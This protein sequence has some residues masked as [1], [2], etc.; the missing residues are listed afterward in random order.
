MG[1]FYN[2][3]LIEEIRVGN[4]IVSVVSEYVKLE[5]KGKNYFGLCP[6]HR[7]KTPSFSI[8]P[9]KQIFYCFGCGKGGN[10]IHFT[11]AAENIE[12]TEAIKFLAERSGVTLPEGDGSGELEKARLRKELFEVNKTAARY[13][14]ENLNSEAGHAAKKY[15]IERGLKENTLRRFG[16]GFSAESSDSLC[17]YMEAHGS[18][19]DMLAK[20]GLAIAGKNHMFYDRFK[21]RVMFP[22]FDLRGNITGFGGRIIEANTS[23]PKYVNSPE[24]PVYSKSR[25][26]YALN[27][28]KNSGIGTLLV[29][30]GYMDV[31]SLHQ[32]G[33]INSVASLGTSLTEGQARL[34]KKYS[35]EIVISF[36]S[37]AAGQSAAMRSL[38][39]LDEMGC[40][41]RVLRIPEGKDPDD[42]IKKK[43]PA[44][45]RK[46]IETAQPVVEYKTAILKQEIDTGSTEGKIKF[47]SRLAEIL[48]KLDSRV[49]MEMYARKIARDYG[50]SEES[51]YGEITRKTKPGTSTR[52]IKSRESASVIKI[53]DNEANKRLKQYEIKLLSVLCTDN[54]AYNDIKG[55]ITPMDF[56]NGSNRKIAEI[57]F[58]RLDNNIE[59]APAELFNILDPDIA[60]DYAGIIEKDCIYD[61]YRKAAAD[62]AVKIKS[63]HMERR[64]VELMETLNGKEKL[65]PEDLKRL[66]GELDGILHQKR[67]K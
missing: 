43:G 6:F 53:T 38:D 12:F 31:I 62:I 52:T 2:D 66:L 42:Y 40:R 15:L 14:Y 55:K 24:T 8:E 49:E 47:I 44:A 16:L 27:L 48:S 30:E 36:D 45:F 17:K 13:F 18:N 67:K 59:I 32:N 4:D 37:D 39:M 35:E 22:I 11:M 60:G 21:G 34:L 26:L 25:S 63:E 54:A 50:I 41:V 61:D 9:L 19:M 10:V 5:R 58:E 51:V 23:L 20:S 29:V 64:H 46:L 7:E 1:N 56:T 33:I 3:D 28:A 65:T 57:I